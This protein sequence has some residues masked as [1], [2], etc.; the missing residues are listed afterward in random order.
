MRGIQSLFTKDSKDLQV[1]RS[2]WKFWKRRDR[3]PNTV[4]NVV[5]QAIDPHSNLIHLGPFQ[6]LKSYQLNSLMLCFILLVLL[7]FYMSYQF[8]RLITLLEV[9][10]F[11]ADDLLRGGVDIVFDFFELFRKY[12][13]LNL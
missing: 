9:L 12:T 1:K 13:I 6:S 8:G 7:L 2:R 10:I 5:N 4:S 3:K 11:G